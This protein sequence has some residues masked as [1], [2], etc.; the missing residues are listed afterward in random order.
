MSF[1]LN[2]LIG[3]HFKLNRRDFDGCDCRGI[4]YLY[5]KYVKNRIIFISDGKRIIF[6][7]RC[8]DYER[9]V[10]IFKSLNFIPI[11]FEDLNEG[12]IVYLKSG[13]KDAGALGICI[14]KY[15]ILHMD[16]IVG[17]C[18]TRIRYL[19]NL[20]LTAYRPKW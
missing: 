6:R 11:K 19:K 14:N 20:F 10:N 5:Y 12:D 8:K 9:M 13:Y 16:A 18:L 3:I 4:V 15:Q 17:S 7:N 2:K 1:N